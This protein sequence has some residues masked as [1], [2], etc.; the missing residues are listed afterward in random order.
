MYFQAFVK[1]NDVPAK[2]LINGNPAKSPNGFLPYLRCDDSTLIAGYD[3]II[4]HF[5]SMVS[6]ENCD[7]TANHYTNPLMNIA[8]YRVTARKMCKTN[9]DR[10]HIFVIWTN[11]LDHIANTCCGATRPMSTQRAPYTLNAHHSPTTLP[12]R[13]NI[14]N[15]P[16]TFCRFTV[17]ST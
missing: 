12:I 3:E 15:V 7:L 9:F 5:K 6:N 10:N 17:D 16:K 2:V 13:R 4:S 1:F 8:L 11:N 14:W